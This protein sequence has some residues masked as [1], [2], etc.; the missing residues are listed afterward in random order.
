MKDSVQGES[1]VWSSGGPLTGSTAGYERVEAP[2][3]NVWMIIGNWWGYCWM[4]NAYSERQHRCFCLRLKAILTWFEKSIDWQVNG[5][6]YGHARLPLGIRDNELQVSL[7]MIE[8]PFGLLDITFM[9]AELLKMNMEMLADWITQ[10]QANLLRFKF[11]CTFDFTT[12][13]NAEGA[14]TGPPQAGWLNL[15]HISQLSL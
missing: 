11:S 14:E 12:G 8:T 1:V 2:Q 13:M 15:R 10:V 9:A 3:R 6:F 7:L 5:I 4:Q